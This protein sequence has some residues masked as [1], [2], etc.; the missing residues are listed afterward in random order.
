MLNTFIEMIVETLRAPREMAGRLIAMQLTSQ[1]LWMGFGLLVILNAVVFFTAQTLLPLPDEVVADMPVV[2]RSPFLFAILLA[3]I[4]VV[5][6]HAIY[7]AGRAM[8]GQA[9]LVDILAVMTWL[10]VLRLV[11]QVALFL[12]QLIAPGLAVLAAMVAGLWGLWLL[13]EFIDVAHRLNNR[14]RALS[15]LI[16]AV[17][18]LFFGLILIVSLIGLVAIGS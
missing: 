12:L 17:M 5:T 9:Q 7:W 18:A 15:V 10:Q 8:G 2:M 6:I 1:T 13:V 4:L 3:G 16:G 14:G 11:A